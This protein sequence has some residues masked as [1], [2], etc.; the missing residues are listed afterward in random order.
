MVIYIDDGTYE[1]VRL[2]RGAYWTD[3]YAICDAAGTPIVWSD[4]GDWVA[5]AEFYNEYGGT[6][7]VDFDTESGVSPDGTITLTDPTEPTNPASSNLTIELGS[8]ASATL[9][10]TQDERGRDTTVY[11]GQLWIWRTSA[12]D[13]KYPAL[14]FRITVVPQG[15]S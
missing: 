11:V 8:A 15:V 9:T 14:E 4:D 12:T 3:N 5:R 7:L 1:P 6:M 13:K 10:A 2:T